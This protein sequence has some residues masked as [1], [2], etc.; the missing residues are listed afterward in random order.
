MKIEIVLNVIYGGVKKMKKKQHE[1]KIQPSVRELRRLKALVN[2]YNQICITMCVN[3]LTDF[4]RL[5]EIDSIIKDFE[6]EWGR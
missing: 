5:M 2:S 6:S 4:E 3:G 1:I